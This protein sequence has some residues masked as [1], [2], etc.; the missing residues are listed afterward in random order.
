MFFYKYLGATH[1]TPELL[2]IQDHTEINSL[3]G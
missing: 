2:M 1:L 3:F